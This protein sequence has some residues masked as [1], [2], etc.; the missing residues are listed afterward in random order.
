MTE[1]DDGAAV[2]EFLLLSLLLLIPIV[3]LVLTLAQVQ[4]AAFAAEAV[5]RDA[6]RAAVVGGV[7][8]LQN[9]A[10]F[11]EAERE[12]RDRANSAVAI[13]LADFRVDSQDA[14]VSLTCSA[15]PCLT[16]GSEVQVSVAIELSLPGIGDLI[17]GVA[18]QVGASGSS[19]VDGYVP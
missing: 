13:T 7:D 3:Y 11:A 4:S 8:A 1:R 12:A 16:A 19:P 2:V 14:E 6:S 17:P 5:A 10:S 18:V 9:G 15:S